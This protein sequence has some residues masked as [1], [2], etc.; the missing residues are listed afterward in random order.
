MTVETFTR[1]NGK[2]YQPRK[3][4]LIAHAWENHDYVGEHGVI[5]FGTLDPHRAIEFA[6]QMC[7]Y[8]FGVT[9]AASCAQPGWYRDAFDS[10]ERRWIDD[11]NRGRPG[12]M[13]TAADT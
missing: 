6:T 13:F 2:S 1:P 3:P 5:I 8:W 9:G 11:P 4:G 12:V 7:G 10:G